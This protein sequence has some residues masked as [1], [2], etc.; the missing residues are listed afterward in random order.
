MRE[1]FFQCAYETSNATHDPAY[2]KKLAIAF[3]VLKPKPSPHELIRIGG[4]IDGAYL[5]P[6]DLA[7]ITDCFS[8]GVNNRK[9]FED[10]LAQKYDVK[11]H[12]CDFSSDVARFS[13]PLIPGMQ[14]FRQCWLDVPGA[15]NA[16]SLEKWVNEQAG[17]K[18]D[19][20]LLQIDIEGAEYRNL[21]NCPNDILKR[22][23]IIVIELHGLDALLDPDIFSAVL[24]PF[25][26]KIGAL[27]SC[28]HAHPNNYEGQVILPGLNANIPHVLELSFIR[29][30]RLEKPKGSPL[31]RPMIPHPLDITNNID[32]EP[33][34]LNERWIDDRRP[35]LSELRLSFDELAFEQRKTKAALDSNISLVNRLCLSGVRATGAGEAAGGPA[36]SAL[37]EVAAG[38]PFRCSSAYGAS[39]ASGM[40]PIRGVVA[41][42]V[43]D[44]FFHT[45]FGVNQF[46]TIDL[47]SKRN[48]QKIE[49][50]NRLDA[51]FD[52][53]KLL[54]LILHDTESVAEGEV[55]LLRPTEAFLN[56]KAPLVNVLSPAVSA[57]YA[58]IITPDY[59]ALHFS[60]VKIFA[61]R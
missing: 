15:K 34:V 30:D 11:S 12:M 59:S 37:V 27:F 39:S 28:V 60:G 16:I 19:D 23:R 42:P 56:G 13:T 7:G 31:Y 1:A 51:C 26:T 5:V 58:T 54:F 47:G 32:A 17:P 9:N 25:F 43:R 50:A 18:S 40:V 14:T 55:V 44:F 35:L 36:E 57:R 53:A 52:R 2:L 8:P 6:N 24:Y 3:D 21:L 33:I 61:G 48:V 10:E 29:K 4:R 38:R 41:A 22:F 45:G 49:I 20:L 46:I